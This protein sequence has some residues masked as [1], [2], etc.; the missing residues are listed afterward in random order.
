[1]NQIFGQERQT[2]QNNNFNNG[3]PNNQQ[4]NNNYYY[5]NNNNYNN[6]YYT[7][8][9]Y[10]EQNPKKRKIY[11]KDISKIL[12]FF[13]ILN[14]IYGLTLIGSGVWGIQLNKP[15]L[16]DTPIVTLDKVGSRV[17]IRIETEF[18]IKYASYRW[19]GGAETEIPTTGSTIVTTAIK[20]IE[21]NNILN[22][23]VTDTYDNIYHY[24]RQYIRN[25]QDNVDPVI[26]V[27]SDGAN[28]TITATD[29]QKIAYISYRWGEEEETFI[30]ATEGIE[31][32]DEKVLT[33]T[34]TARR[35]ANILTINAQ[36]AEENMAKPVTYN[37]QAAECPTVELSYENGNL[38]IYTKD[39]I[40]LK[41]LT[42]VLDGTTYSQE[43]DGNP[44]EYK[45]AIPL[46]SGT[47]EIS[48][49]VTNING[50]ETPQSG[51]FTI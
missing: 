46:E 48:I 8:Y 47:H 41:T 15:K 6:N 18:P 31:G 34:I 23:T 32:A 30:R 50:Y 14:I 49:T 27:T 1:M 13:C 51:T 36:D 28:I 2:K 4:L 44:L 12:V 11:N 20:V 29:D 19:N 43:L 39:D 37:V 25:S 5:N 24:K 38:I 7:N 45:A 42:I 10:E 9:D 33:T 26:S 3:Y 40:G 22:I 35:G 16:A 17:T 21:G